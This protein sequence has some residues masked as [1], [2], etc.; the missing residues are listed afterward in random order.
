MKTDLYIDFDSTIVATEEAFCAVYNKEYNQFEGFVKADWREARSWMFE[1]AC[2]LIQKQHKNPQKEIVRIFGTHDFFHELE[3]FDH[4]IEVLK[5]LEDQY[6]L[7]ICT[8]AMPENAS[9]KVLWIEEHLD[10]VDEVIVL[11]NKKQNGVGKKRVPMNERNSIFIDDHP[12][13]LAS[14]NA[15]RKILYKNMEKDFNKTWQGEVVTSW[16]QVRDKLL[17]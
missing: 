13:N 16:L 1:N 10:F 2:P 7:I 6:N 15:S 11:I 12:H 17:K 8:S 5:A 4:A 9:R 3:P 14:T